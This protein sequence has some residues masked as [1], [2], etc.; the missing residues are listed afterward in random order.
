MPFCKTVDMSRDQNVSEFLHYSFAFITLV[1]VVSVILSYNCFIHL[2]LHLPEYEKW[3]VLV[4]ESRLLKRIALSRRRSRAFREKVDLKEFRDSSG[5]FKRVKSI[6]E[7]RETS[8]LRHFVVSLVLS[9]VFALGLSGSP[10][11][12]WLVSAKVVPSNSQ[13]WGRTQSSSVFIVEASPLSTWAGLINRHFTESAAQTS[14][15]ESSN[16]ANQPT[17]PSS[18]YFGELS[19]IGNCDFENA[20]ADNLSV[21]QTG[22][23]ASTW[24]TF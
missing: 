21:D 5:R 3:I 10:L 18:R 15:A 12:D 13:I 1:N 11:P 4:S 19:R 14:L 24:Q 23:E 7:G 16:I 6:F 17:A 9:S 20:D 2:I 22:C 8:F